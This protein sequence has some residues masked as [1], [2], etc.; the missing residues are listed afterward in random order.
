MKVPAGADPNTFGGGSSPQVVFTGARFEMQAGSLMVEKVNAPAIFTV[1]FDSCSMGGGNIPSTTY[2]M[3]TWAGAGN[4]ELRSCDGFTN[5]RFGYTADGVSDN[6]LRVRIRNC[7]ITKEFIQDST[8]TLSTGS[9]VGYFPIF[10]VLGCGSRVDGMYRPRDSEFM[11]SA[12]D[13]YNGVTKTL[14]GLSFSPEAN[15]MAITAGQTYNVY[16]PSTRVIG[17]RVFPVANP[18]GAGNATITIKNAAGTVTLGTA[19][20]TMTTPATTLISVDCNYFVDATAGD[21]LT[22]EFAHSYTPGVALTF[23]GQL[24]LLY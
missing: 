15:A 17:I 19:T 22:V 6:I 5:Y 13:F 18:G 1:T 9:N 23:K 16:V 21:Y 3:F 4:L 24:Y 20:W 8:F 12:L 11:N 10:D 14:H 2:K 7:V